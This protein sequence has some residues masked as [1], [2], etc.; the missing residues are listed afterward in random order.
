MPNQEKYR[1]AWEFLTERARDD[2]SFSVE[3]LA[4]AADWTPANTRTNLSKRLGE[5]VH[6]EGTR[7]YARPEILRV[8]YEDFEDLFRQKQRLFADYV[9]NETASVLV[10]E[11]F[12]PLARED[13]LREALVLQRRLQRKRAARLNSPYRFLARLRAWLC[14]A[15]SF[16]LWVSTNHASSSAGVQRRLG[17]SS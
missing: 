7:L 3:D 13:R 12:M 1:R 2:A 5:L 11:F 4:A 8:R 10:Y 14:S 6:K 16:R 9:L 17:K 15:A